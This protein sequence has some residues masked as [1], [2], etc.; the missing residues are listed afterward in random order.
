MLRAP[1]PEFVFEAF[2]LE[3]SD[4]IVQDEKSTAPHGFEF[5]VD[6]NVDTPYLQITDPT[7]VDGYTWFFL[8]IPSVAMDGFKAG[9]I[10][11]FSSVH[12]N[13]YLYVTRPVVGDI[14]LADRIQPGSI[15]P[16]MFPGNNRFAFYFPDNF[17]FNNIWYYPTYW[18]V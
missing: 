17:E 7:D 9:D 18:G 15:W 1:N 12:N 8:V 4:F 2:T 10:I 3:A 5:G 13:K 16:I 11:H 14:Q 6:V